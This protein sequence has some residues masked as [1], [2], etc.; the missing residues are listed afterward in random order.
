MKKLILFAALLIT[1]VS[2]GRQDE[3]N[4]VS[5]N[6][7]GYARYL[8]M[9]EQ[10]H[11]L[12]AGKHLSVGTVTYGIDDNA[13]FYVTYDCGSTD[14]SIRETHLFAGDKA[15][16]PLN[17]CSHPR[18]CRFPYHAHHYPRVKT[19]TYRIPL[20]TLPPAEEPGFAVAAECVVY[21]STKCEGQE[22]IAWAEGDFKF[23]D[24]GKGWYDVFFF[25]QLENEYVIL[26]GLSYAND[27]LK[28][29]H[30]DVTNNSVELTFTE[31]VGNTPGSYDGAA[32]DAESGMLIFVKVND[33]ELFV[34]RMDDEDS[35]FSAGTLTGDVFSATYHDG[36]YYYVDAG[37]NTIHG[38]TFSQD[39]TISGDIILDALPP[40]VVVNDIAMDP[41]GEVL[42]ILGSD[43]SN[44]TNL[45]SWDLGTETFY[46]HPVTINNGGQIAFGSD[47]LLY[48]LAPLYEQ[49]TANWVYV[50]DTDSQ[51]LMVIQDEIIIID[52]PFSDMASGPSM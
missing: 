29:Y 30:L 40:S 15:A 36:V 46:S 23:T 1:A 17:R 24:K 52:D 26:Y 20:S 8:K 34:N 4:A 25:N 16:M 22:K 6:W 18:V 12:W 50:I 19:Y 28:L 27:S 32:Y 5:D 38:V 9:G 51:D 39:W 42:Y 11:T 33:G 35:S 49:G 48:A 43:G 45:I 31:Y 2:C 41:A 3:E 44:G 14:W 13:N 21:R 37:T 7:N 10:V 47:G